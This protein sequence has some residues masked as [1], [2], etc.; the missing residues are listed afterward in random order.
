MKI[1]KITLKIA[2]VMC[3]FSLILTSFSAC[4]EKS[5]EF[6]TY[7]LS[8]VMT[9]KISGTDEEKNADVMNTLNAAVRKTEKAVSV[10]DENSEINILNST[11]T[12]YASDYFRKLMNECLIIGETTQK[13]ANV[14]LGEITSLWGFYGDSPAVPDENELKKAV[15]GIGL[16]K[17]ELSQQ[18]NK[19]SLPSD[20]SVD[21]HSMEHGIVL[22]S[23]YEEVKLFNTPIMLTLG[24]TVLACGRGPS[25]GR[26]QI[27]IP[28]YDGKKTVA[29]LRL[30]PAT[31]LNMLAVSTA[32]VTDCSFT[33]DGVTYHC[34]V[35]PATGRPVETD[36]VSV[37]VTAASA[38]NA[39][40]LS[41]A[42]FV[43]GFSEDTLTYLSYFGAEA[44]F[45]FNDGTYY[46]TDG[47]ADSLSIK[48]RGLTLTSTE[49]TT[50]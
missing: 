34:H 40:A 24:N 10:K 29:S 37:T 41:S 5:T 42:C 14:S 3:V 30:A 12:L 44:L 25:S 48:D 39:D 6:Q 43:T 36:L 13:A 4:S 32:Y 22:D 45:I 1:T 33:E 16:W 21:L 28:S 50:D 9:I 35:S 7:A 8:D 17:I 47:L 19:I 27:D 18:N 31:D 11:K 20:L 26:W 15:D 23:A 46:A 2:A 49:I 38:L